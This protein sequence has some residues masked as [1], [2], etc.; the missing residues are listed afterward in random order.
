[1]AICSL[2]DSSGFVKLSGGDPT[3][4]VGPVLLSSL[5]YQ[6]Y[7]GSLSNFGWDE[8]SFDLAFG[9]ALLLF[10]IGYGVGLIV[11]IVRRTRL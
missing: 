1:M 8:A 9:G 5:E 7:L 4:C 10:V 2:I 3:S 6:G 11:N